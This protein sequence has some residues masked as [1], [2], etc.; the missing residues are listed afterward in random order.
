MKKYIKAL[1]WIA[2][3]A[4]AVVSC[5]E[6]IQPHEP[7]DPDASGCYG[8]Y[9]PTQ[10]AS[11]SHV[12]SPIE[13]PSVDITLKRT[14]ASGAITVPIMGSYSEDGIFVLGEAAF[15]DGQDETTFTVRFDNAKEGTNYKASF[16]IEDH[17][18]ASYY[19]NNAISLDF[20]VMRV[21]M[22]YFLNPKTGEKA[23]VHWVQGW[24]GEEVDTYL[25]YYEV[26][27]VQTF[28]TETIPSS[29]YYKGYYDGY[30][31]WGASDA[32]GE[33][34]WSFVLYTKNDNFI[35]IP[36]QFTGSHN[37][38]YDADIYALDY[39]YWN[40][41]DPDDESEFLEYAADNDD[42]VSY[43]DGNG[44]FY[45]SVRSYYMFGIGGW[46]PGAYDTYGIAEGFVR[47]DYALKGIEADFTENGVLPLEVYAGVDVKKAQFVV[48]AGELTAT[49]VG[50]QVA[51]I[52]AGTAENV[53]TLDKFEATEYKEK[54]AQVAAT[55]VTLNETGVYTVVAVTFDG[56]G[57]VADSGSLV[58]KYVAAGDEEANAVDLT[59]GI[60]SAAK[61]AGQGVNT[62]TALEIWAY[63]TDI[64]DAKIAAVKYMD[65][66]ADQEAALAA[67]KASKSLSE[68]DLATLNADGY[69]SVAEKLLPG[70]EYFAVV[71]AS[72]GY[73]EAYFISDESC[74]TTGDPLPI[75]QTYTYQ[76]F[77]EE[78]APESQKDLIGKTFNLYGTNLQ[79]SL[80]MNE[81]LGQVKITDSEAEDEGPDEDGL[82]DEYVTLTGLAGPAAAKNG[83]D[84]SMTF[85]LYGGYLYMAENSTVDGEVTVYNLTETGSGYNA[86]YQA[87]FIPVMD[88]Y[89]AYVCNSRYYSSYNWNGLA[90]VDDSGPVALYTNYILV[91]PEKD[92]NGIAPTPSSRI[93]KHIDF[94]VK[95]A[96]EKHKSALRE[97]SGKKVVQVRDTRAVK[98]ACP[99]KTVRAK[100]SHVDVFVSASQNDAHDNRTAP[101]T[102]KR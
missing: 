56:D 26:D 4:F 13:D 46:N 19:G 67:V 44:G 89:F 27:G 59:T 36:L 33:G 25:K 64:V 43:Y 35:R 40:A 12:Y 18:Y 14:N 100:L 37:S 94:T 21:E 29:H 75:Y 68:E 70:T 93:S 42:V 28:F 87:Y 11:G 62:D 38:S 84:D 3:A 69:V 23:K 92:D 5:Q 52:E 76:D 50:N 61:Y 80:G 97:R 34:E 8:V 72:N 85:D 71:W 58:V 78:F 54:A 86:A 90:F 1:A 6:K 55:G 48:A 82:Y 30:G 32:E 102:E 73:E 81:Y 96:V 77:N 60:G 22:K 49:Q 79:G 9:F 53:Y 20:S 74:F 63:G 101:L 65:L 16:T 66:A 57:K 95:G 31:F 2:A 45:L 88:G 99:V 7:G 51:A 10:A 41:E 24:W 17:Q 39:F 98:G 47:V 83:F 91:D 15:A